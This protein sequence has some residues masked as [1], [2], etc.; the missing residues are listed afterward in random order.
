MPGTEFCSSS[1]VELQT[2]FCVLLFVAVITCSYD[3]V[4]STLCGCALSLFCAGFVSK[5]NLCPKC[6]FAVSIYLCME[7]F[8]IHFCL[9]VSYPVVLI[10]GYC[11]DRRHVVS[12]SRRL[13]PC[14]SWVLKKSWCAHY[15]HHEDRRLRSVR[16]L[17]RCSGDRGRW[18]RPSRS[19]RMCR[20]RFEDS[21]HQQGIPHSFPHSGCSRGDQWRTG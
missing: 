15:H 10:C 8:H 7:P 13:P 19:G 18:R 4:C 17:L 20:S 5:Q 12:I 16:S 6:R 3:H 21:V 1:V 2:Q 9:G 11:P 14:S